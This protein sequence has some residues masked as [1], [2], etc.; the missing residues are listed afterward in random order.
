MNVRLRYLSSTQ[1][2][3]VIALL[4]FFFLLFTGVDAGQAIRLTL[5]VG[6][7]VFAG[8]FCWSHLR[9]NRAQQVEVIGVALMLGP[10]LSTLAALGI[11]VAGL[12]SWGWLIPPAAVAIA[13]LFGKFFNK[14]DAVLLPVRYLLAIKS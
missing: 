7:Q 4:G 13:W 8:A 1:L 6:L 3:V 11:Q 9:S 5:I 2:G 10:I 12:G 14:S